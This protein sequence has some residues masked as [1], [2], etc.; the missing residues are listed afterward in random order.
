[1]L[2][3]AEEQQ[4]LLGRKNHVFIELEKQGTLSGCLACAVVRTEL[5][6]SGLYSCAYIELHETLNGVFLVIVSNMVYL[7]I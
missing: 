5:T 6:F 3:W 1:L 4:E 2:A 7:V